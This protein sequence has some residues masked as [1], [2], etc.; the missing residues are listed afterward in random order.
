MWH[1]AKL[2]TEQRPDFFSLLFHNS[3]IWLLYNLVVLLIDFS[4]WA[5]DFCSS[6]NVTISL[7]ITK[8][9]KFLSTLFTE[10]GNWL[11]NIFLQYKQRG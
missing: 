10:K 4:T 2:Q 9:A 3:K 5:V 7:S 11:H 1:T 8:N 6:F